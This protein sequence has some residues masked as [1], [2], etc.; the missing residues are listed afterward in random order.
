MM[1]KFFGEIYWE[2][3]DIILVIESRVGIC[4][5]TILILQL[6]NKTVSLKTNIQILKLL[7]EEGRENDAVIEQQF[8]DKMD[9]RN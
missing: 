5:K 8:K 4:L 9:V 7:L 3:N 6:R 2:E 1:P